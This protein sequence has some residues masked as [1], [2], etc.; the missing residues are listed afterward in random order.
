MAAAR[1]GAG[2]AFVVG[3]CSWHG[4]PVLTSLAVTSE[5]ATL[6]KVVVHRPGEEIARMTQHQLDRLLF[7]DLLS[8]ESAKQEHDLMTDILRGGGTQVM[9]ISELLADAL[10]RAPADARHKLLTHVCTQ[11]AAGSLL[12]VIAHWP[13]P[14]LAAALIEG[15]S[16]NDLGHSPMT[17]MRLR[18]RLTADHTALAP[19]PN[20]MFMRDPCITINDRIVVGRMATAARAR[21]PLLV[22]FAIKHAAAVGGR[23]LDFDTSRCGEPRLE[24]GDVLVLSPQVLVIGCSQRTSADTI[25]RLA[26]EAVFETFAQIERIYVVFMPE[27]RSMM[28]LDTVVTQVDEQLFLGHEPLVAGAQALPLACLERAKPARLLSDATLLDVLKDELGQQ[29]TLVPC[30]GRD[31]IHQQREQ[32]TDGANALCLSP[33]HIILYA[34]NVHTVEALR[35]HG[36]EQVSLHTLQPADERSQRIARGMAAP[37]AVFS[38]SGSELSRARGGGR[39]LTMPIVRGA[40]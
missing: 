34:R 14:Q 35:E 36:F 13:A 18:R 21:E 37:R 40:A 26:R 1:R 20:L 28:H 8:P 33:G 25:E 6:R 22:A 9:E 2:D 15:L 12:E 31:P 38:F 3:F 39:C 11:A 10:E 32:W 7:D 5:T 16:W 19:V 4:G 24:G 30:G 27:Q 17:L 23:V 29:L